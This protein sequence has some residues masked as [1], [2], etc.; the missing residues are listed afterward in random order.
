MAGINI[1]SNN[2]A[3]KHRTIKGYSSE[4]TYRGIVF[5]IQKVKHGYRAYNYNGSN[6]IMTKDCNSPKEAIQSAMNLID[7]VS[8]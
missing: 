6:S 2:E 3:I 7:G 1:A 5:F 8:V 4:Q